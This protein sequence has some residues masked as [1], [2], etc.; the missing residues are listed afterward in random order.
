MKRILS[1]GLILLLLTSALLLIPA[2]PAKASP[3]TLELIDP[4]DGDHLFSYNT[5]QKAVGDTFIVEVIVTN[6]QD[7]FA[8]QIKV[9]WDQELLDFE[10]SILPPNHVFAGKSYLEAPVIEEPGSVALGITLGPGQKGV[11]V[12]KGTLVQLKLKII[13]GVSMLGPTKVECDLNFV[14]TDYTFLLNSA[15]TVIPVDWVIAHYSYE[16]V[17][18]A[19]LPRFYIKPITIKPAK[20]G[21][22]FAVEIWVADV[23]PGWEIIAFQFSIMWN[24]TLIEPVE[25]FW[26]KGTFLEAFQYAPDG[27]LYMASIN[28]HARPPPMTSL[29]HDYNYSTIA[30]LLLPDPKVNYTYHAPFPKG[31]GKLATLYFKAIFETI[32]PQEIW[33][34]IE[35]VTFRYPTG[36]SEDMLVLNRYGMDVGYSKADPASYRAPVKA[37]GLSIDVYTQYPNPYGGQGL[38]AVSDMF[39]PQ[40]QVELFALVTYNEYPVQQKL[41]AFEIRHNNYTIWRVATTDADGIAHIS[42]RIPWPCENPEKE[43]FGEWEVIATVEVAEQKKNDTLKFWVWWPVEVLSI[44]SKCTTYKQ[45]KKGVDM[46]FSLEYGTHRMQPINVSLTVTVYDELGFF[47][48]S[49]NFNVTIGWSEYDHFGKMKNYTHEVTI[50]IPSNAVVG[51]CTVYA[52]AFDKFPWLGGTPYCPEVKN[53]E[54][55][56]LVK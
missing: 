2:L 16:W 28:E 47:I 54:E 45:T 8:W 51:V 24:T 40:Q 41:V 21:D 19:K 31:E 6:V 13:K 26:E 34:K 15:G 50:H 30:L 53:V 29:P 35:F 3:G 1:Y 11:N 20:L 52:N 23:D 56:R 18:P 9:T 36:E 22:T 37:L 43:I 14:D 12:T 5:T 10:E 48:G 27:V 42:F 39:G 7:L 25:P 38:N 46:T 17:K 4:E 33:S 44:E 49:C 55:F 32:A